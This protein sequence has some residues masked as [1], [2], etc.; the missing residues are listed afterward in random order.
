MPLPS[1]Q[2][3]TSETESP[4]AVL[5][6]DDAFGAGLRV[7][8]DIADV[9]YGDF[10]IAEGP[11]TGTAKAE[12]EIEDQR[13]GWHA[14]KALQNAWHIVHAAAAPAPDDDNL[15]GL[16]VHEPEHPGIGFVA[17]VNKIRTARAAGKQ[18]CT[19]MHTEMRLNGRRIKHVSLIENK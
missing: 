5:R 1:L 6:H 8:A 7:V 16:K 18:G 13:I 2:G 19:A 3:R 12:L 14:V 11:A 4:S 15:V 17:H 10:K 9:S